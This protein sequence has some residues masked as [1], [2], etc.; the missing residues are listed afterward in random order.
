[1]GELYVRIRSSMP[2]G[3]PASLTPEAYADVV[4]YLLAANAF[5]A[6]RD[7]LPHH[8]ESLHGIVFDERAD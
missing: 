5:P 3:R 2:P 1:V 7:E 4:A 8:E 6:G